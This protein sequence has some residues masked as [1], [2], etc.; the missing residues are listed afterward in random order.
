MNL[1][2]TVRLVTEFS[3]HIQEKEKVVISESG[4]KTREDVKKLNQAGCYGFLVG[5]SFMKNN[6]IKEA[7]LE[8]FG[9]T[10][11]KQ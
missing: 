4:I 6:D 8:V 7:F 2:K 1:D 5:T 10:G 9:D 11:T 3:S